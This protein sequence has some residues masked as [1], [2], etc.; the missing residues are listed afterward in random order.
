MYAKLPPRRPAICLP[1]PVGYWVLD[2]LKRKSLGTKTS[3]TKTRGERTYHLVAKWIPPY[4]RGE[5]P[6]EHSPTVLVR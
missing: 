6:V 2:P 3:P 4:T 1:G 5:G